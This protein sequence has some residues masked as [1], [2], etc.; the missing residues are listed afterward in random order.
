M[1]RAPESGSHRTAPPDSPG[2]A[3][4]PAGACR[5][6][7]HRAIDTEWIAAIR[8]RCSLRQYYQAFVVVKPCP[9][10]DDAALPVGCHEAR[11][12]HRMSLQQDPRRAEL[13][14]NR[15]F[16]LTSNLMIESWHLGHRVA[17]V[18]SSTLPFIYSGEVIH[19]RRYSLK[20]CCITEVHRLLRGW[21]CDCATTA[22]WSWHRMIGCRCESV[23]LRQEG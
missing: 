7:F 20:R 21:A 11:P 6:G 8:R 19:R 14:A 9:G 23:L 4:C 5:A 13:G 18:C 1:P 16:Y 10:I 22:A 3:A 17:K 12:V 2:E 15:P